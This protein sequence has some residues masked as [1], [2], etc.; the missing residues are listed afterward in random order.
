MSIIPLA[1]LLNISINWQNYTLNSGK[2][3]NFL[4]INQQIKNHPT[5]RLIYRIEF[6][7]FFKQ[8]AKL[9]KGT[10][11]KKV[12]NQVNKMEYGQKRDGDARVAKDSL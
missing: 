8:R 12:R 3:I 10:E 7:W 2:V 4:N 6:V 9:N 11:C 5:K 1:I